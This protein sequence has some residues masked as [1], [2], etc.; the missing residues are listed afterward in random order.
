MLENYRQRKRLRK[1]IR[2]ADALQ[3]TTR[4]RQYVIPIG[5]SYS[6]VDN[7][8]I[9]VYNRRARRLKLDKIDVRYLLN[10]CCYRTINQSQIKK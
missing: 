1:A 3:K 5:K 6:V 10:N 2:K 8:Y 9:E 4:K 7:T